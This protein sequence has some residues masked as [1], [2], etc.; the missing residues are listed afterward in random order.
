MNEQFTQIKNS[1]IRDINI[2]S[3]QYRIISYL[4]SISNNG[5]AFP[6]VR[7]MG[8]ELDIAPSTILRNLEQ[9]EHKKYIK[10]TNMQTKNGKIASNQYRLKKELFVIP[11]KKELNTDEFID[12]DWMNEEVL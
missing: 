7:T 6:S 10:K 5:V 8:K 2:T 1:L 11:K 3:T 4:L 9:L 12:Y